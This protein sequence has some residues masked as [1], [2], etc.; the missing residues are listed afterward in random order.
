MALKFYIQ[1][2]GKVSGPLSGSELMS[3]AQLGK[4]LPTDL[5]RQDGVDKWVQAAKIRNLDFGTPQEEEVIEVIEE[6]ILEVEP[7]RPNRTPVVN[8]P[9]TEQHFLINDDLP[10]PPNYGFVDFVAGIYNFLGV[11]TL[12]GSVI[13]VFSILAMESNGSGGQKAGVIF[14]IIIFGA[15]TAITCFA[16]AQLFA[17]AI[18]GSKN[19]HYILHSNLVVMRVMVNQFGKKG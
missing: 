9:P 1:V 13:A 10:P 3:L 8:K 4:L 5:V 19:I 11:L 12:I 18:N 14:A 6:E 16:M 15:I 2:K 7:V 17:M